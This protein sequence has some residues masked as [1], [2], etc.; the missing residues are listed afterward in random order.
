MRKSNIQVVK[1]QVLQID[2][3][4]RIFICL[5]ANHKTNKDN[6]GKKHRKRL[7]LSNNHA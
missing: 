5:T 3:I 1:K 4:D 7:P 6:Y 2:Q